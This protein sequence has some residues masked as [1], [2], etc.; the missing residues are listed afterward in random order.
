[1]AFHNAGTAS[2]HRRPVPCR[3]CALLLLIKITCCVLGGGMAI[4]GGHTHV[5]SPRLVY[6]LSP[7]GRIGGVNPPVRW[8]NRMAHCC[9]PVC[10]AECPC[11]V[12]C[13][14]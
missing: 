10:H 7:T 14:A 11:G 5:G 4:G 2:Y 9:F 8:L 3:T 13:G 12:L 1:M 6:E